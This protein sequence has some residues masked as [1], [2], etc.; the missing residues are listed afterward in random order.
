MGR[1]AAAR[2][3]FG[4]RNRIYVSLQKKQATIADVCGLILKPQDAAALMFV[5]N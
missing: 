3:L 4:R 2:Q 1:Y 5:M